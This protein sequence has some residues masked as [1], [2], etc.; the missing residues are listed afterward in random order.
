MPSDDCQQTYTRPM[1]QKTNLKINP[2][3]DLDLP[4][5]DLEGYESDSILTHLTPQ[6]SCPSNWTKARTL[7]N[8]T[9]STMIESLGP[10]GSVEAAWRRPRKTRNTPRNQDVFS[11]ITL[12]D[13]IDIYRGSEVFHVNVPQPPKVLPFHRRSNAGP[14]SG[15]A[16]VSEIHRIAKGDQFDVEYLFG[17]GPVWNYYR[18][19]L[20]EAD[21]QNPIPI[22]SESSSFGTPSY[23]SDWFTF[24][25]SKPP[26]I[27]WLPY[28]WVPPRQWWPFP[29]SQNF[30][31]PYKPF[32]DFPL[33]IPA[34]HR[35]PLT[36]DSHA[37]E[38][39]SN[40]I[41]R[42]KFLPWVRQ[43]MDDENLFVIDID[44]QNHEVSYCVRRPEET[45]ETLAWQIQHAN[46]PP[47]AC[48]VNYT[49]DQP[50]RPLD[51]QGS[52]TP[53]YRVVL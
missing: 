13:C 18:P 42:D 49:E 2:S 48:I 31:S 20:G 33:V 19:V 32:W 38:Q 14:I 43:I 12:Q 30:W 52:P 16:D 7:S 47:L 24:E 45:L 22:C 1:A 34:D 53:W 51:L 27:E 28:P 50:V 46:F 17:R 25:S 5:E 40:S 21:D 4:S 3:G 44:G 11:D 8:E 15:D 35:L 36:I 26:T 6:L 41:C 37:R 39:F 29:P 9:E 23:K 10:G